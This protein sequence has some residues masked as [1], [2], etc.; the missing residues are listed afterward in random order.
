VIT[1]F[2]EKKFLR[3]INLRMSFSVWWLTLNTAEREE[4]R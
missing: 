3:L 1:V 4:K 2:R